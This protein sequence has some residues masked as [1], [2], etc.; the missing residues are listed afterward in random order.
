MDFIQN[1]FT[2]E[3]AENAEKNNYF[4]N[5]KGT[6][7]IKDKKVT[8]ALRLTL[9]T[10]GAETQRTQR[11]TSHKGTKTLR[12]IKTKKIRRR[13]AE[14]AEKCLITNKLRK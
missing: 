6:K 7:K 12:R 9:F 11:K 5:H 3:C 14:D 13:D 2:A 4:S 8:A 1:T 10:Q